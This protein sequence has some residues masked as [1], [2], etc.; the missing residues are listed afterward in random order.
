MKFQIRFVVDELALGPVL[1][2]LNSHDGVV[3]NHLAIEPLTPPRPAPSSARGKFAQQERDNADPAKKGWMGKPTPKASK[4][5]AAREIVLDLL[6]TEGP[7]SFS[8]IKTVLVS[9]G[10][11]ASGVGSLIN[12]RMKV[13]GDIVSSEPGIWALAK[14]KEG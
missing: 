3:F 11:A 9:R 6:A 7:Q 5:Q 10:F 2:A 12:N 4:P 1:A 8:R 13:Y 14:P